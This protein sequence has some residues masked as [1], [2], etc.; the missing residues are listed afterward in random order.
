LLI[1][2]R[3]D[4]VSATESTPFWDGTICLLPQNRTRL[5]VAYANDHGV[6]DFG[7]PEDWTQ[8]GWGALHGRQQGYQVWY[9][10]VRMGRSGANTTNAVRAFLAY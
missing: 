10:D 9:R 5:N 2:N 4:L 3:A 8:G 1:A 6:A 7:R